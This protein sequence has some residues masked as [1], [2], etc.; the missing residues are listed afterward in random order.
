MEI[1]KILLVFTVLGALLV[2]GI[3]TVAGGGDGVWQHEGLRTVP[4]PNVRVFELLTDPDQRELWVEGLV[5]SRLESGRYVE[6]GSRLHET[7]EIDGV[8]R[9]RVLEAALCDEPKSLTWRSV[10][11][12][13]AIEISYRMAAHLTGKQTKLETTCKATFPGWWARIGEPLLGGALL[14]RFESDLD[15]LEAHVLR[16]P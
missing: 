12:G 10:E 6:Q 5:D 11:D 2:A 8:R 14:E 13:V 7:L 15:R 1:L 9:Q 16:H 4:A 3:L